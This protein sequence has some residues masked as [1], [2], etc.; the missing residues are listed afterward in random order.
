MQK[1]L[2]WKPHEENFEFLYRGHS[3]GNYL[4][5]ILNIKNIS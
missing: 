4:V 5:E 3:E 1:I 2:S